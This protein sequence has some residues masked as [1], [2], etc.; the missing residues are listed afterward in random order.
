MKEDQE[1]V[2][3]PEVKRKMVTVKETGEINPRDNI[4]RRVLKKTMKLLKLPKLQLLK[5]Q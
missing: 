1:L 2:V 4:K 3:V 5:S